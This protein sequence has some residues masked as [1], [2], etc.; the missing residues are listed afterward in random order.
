MRYRISA[1]LPAKEPQG[2]CLPT[3]HLQAR[4]LYLQNGVQFVILHTY[5]KVPKQKNTHTQKIKKKRSYQGSAQSL[6]VEL[7]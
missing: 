7:P 6:I 4:N 5:P 3:A 1:I 2:P